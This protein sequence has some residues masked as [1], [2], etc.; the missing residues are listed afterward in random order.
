M[1][2]VRARP[3][4]ARLHY[5]GGFIESKCAFRGDRVEAVRWEPWRWYRR[6][7]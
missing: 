2:P 5:C 1:K 3:G 7:V 6:K 4:C